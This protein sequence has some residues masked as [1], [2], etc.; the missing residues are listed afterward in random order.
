MKCPKCKELSNKKENIIRIFREPFERII[1]FS[2]KYMCLKCG[3]K[4]LKI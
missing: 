4:F 2:K 3:I 1:P